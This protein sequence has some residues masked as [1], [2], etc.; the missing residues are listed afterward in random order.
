VRRALATTAVFRCNDML[1]DIMRQ[2]VVVGGVG[3]RKSGCGPYELMHA[4]TDSYSSAH[5]ERRPGTH[6][7]AGHEP[8]R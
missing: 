4:V 2:V 6:R 5:T 1:D 3:T 7:D 8:A